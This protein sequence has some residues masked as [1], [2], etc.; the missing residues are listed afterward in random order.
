M[1]PPIALLPRAV[2]NS[3]NY[4]KTLKTA[5]AAFNSVKGRPAFTTASCASSSST[6]FLSRSKPRLGFWETYFNK[7]GPLRRQRQNISQAYLST[8]FLLPVVMVGI[9]NHPKVRLAKCKTELAA[10][11]LCGCAGVP[12]L[13]S[14][15]AE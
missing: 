12:D 11:G 10:R 4:S 8:V 15:G 14:P 6:S 5:E 2:G 7:Q 9:G 3:P 13:G 1:A